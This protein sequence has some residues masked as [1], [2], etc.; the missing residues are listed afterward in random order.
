MCLMTVYSLTM[1]L[2]P[3]MSR[4]DRAT[5]SAT[6]TLLRLANETCSGRIVPASFIWPSRIQT[7]WPLVISVEAVVLGTRI[8]PRP[9][10]DQMILA[11]KQ[12]E[13][14]RVVKDHHTQTDQHKRY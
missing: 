6:C 7:S 2:A 8:A 4:A 13:A 12:F 14:A 5:S 3:S 11:A 10:R 9:Y 1:P